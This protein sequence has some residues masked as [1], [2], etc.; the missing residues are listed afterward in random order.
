MEWYV[1]PGD[2]V[3]VTELRRQIRSYLERHADGEADLMAAEVVVSEL[4]TNASTHAGGPVW[5]SLTWREEQP[6]LRV[7]DLGPG[8]D[9]VV[10]LPDD[11]LA[12]GG[13]G[14]YLVDQM[15]SDVRV[16]ERLGGG[17][18]VSAR[19]PVHRSAGATLG[20]ARRRS[21]AL[22]ALD[23]AQPQGGFGRESFL[24]AL[25]VQLAQATEEV[26]GP[27]AAEAALAQ[28]GADVGGQMEDEFRLAQG[29]TGR[30]TPKEMA[31]CYVRLKAAIDGG[32][33]VLEVDE[34]RIVLV[35]D[36]CPFG[37]VVQRAPALCHM[38]SSVFG[39]IAARNGDGEALVELEER[40]AVGD[41]HC[42]VVVWLQPPPERPSWAHRYRSGPAVRS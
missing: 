37:D 20:S 29:I 22:P 4:I 11:A 31:A 19:L 38:T 36:R 18:V 3:A 42:R 39:G 2:A 40:I 12:D 41:P 23:E 13:R 14:L 16:E 8:F 32:F 10:A 17:A 27:V 35:N 21:G 34:R 26:H 6:L 28:V 33:E 5:V 30:L 25:V 9:P 15:A 7:A 1:E 24:R